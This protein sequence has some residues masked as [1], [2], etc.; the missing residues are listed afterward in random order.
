VLGVMSCHAPA[1][2]EVPDIAQ[3][4]PV[5]EVSRAIGAPC[6]YQ[7]QP[8]VPL[9]PM[10]TAEFTNPDGKTVLQAVVGGGP[11]LAA[12][13]NAQSKGTPL[14]GIGDEAFAT[15]HV[16]VARRGEFMVSLRLRGPAKDTDPRNLYW[17]LAQVVGR[18]PVAVG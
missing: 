16:A 1:G 18:L 5:D 13:R 14:P 2:P 4:I 3:L 9:M 15:D 17:L 6:A 7:E 10:R 11:F 12:A 8:P